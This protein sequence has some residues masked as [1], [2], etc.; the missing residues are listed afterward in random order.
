MR[1]RA[2]II[3]CGKIGSEFAGDPKIRGVYTH[4]GA[5]A[6]HPGCELVAVCDLDPVR[7][8]N[9]A[10][11]WNLPASFTDPLR[12]LAEA[13]PE[14]VSICTPDA[15]HAAMLGAVL[16]SAGIRAVLAEKPLALDVAEARDLVALAARRQVRLAV[17]YSR[18]FA[19]GHRRAAE[20]IRSGA[21][22]RIQNITGKYTKGIRHNGSHWFDLAR[23]FAGEAAT[24]QGFG[25]A[26][27][28]DTDPTI[29]AR[30]VFRS[31]ATAWLQGCAADAFT[32]FELDVIGTAGRLLFT[33]SG[34]RIEHFTVG[35][36]PRYSGYRAA[37][38]A[39]TFDGG[40]DDVLAGAV[41]D[42]IASL[43]AGREPACSGADGV[44][45][46]ALAAAAHQSSLTGQPVQMHAG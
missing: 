15:T 35:D 9:C 39:E 32:V 16:G 31:G 30:V 21:L 23:W 22:G 4:A 43:D 38:P 11:R 45:A 24:V 3:G 44:A 29:D 14:I 1:Y 26:A 41:T 7:A 36:S 42:L 34:H 5:Y 33:D 19:P 17:N 12:M 20:L 40:L 25:P 46:L 2:A 13:R 18:R 10:R 28:G 6:A 37:Q 8:E 27:G